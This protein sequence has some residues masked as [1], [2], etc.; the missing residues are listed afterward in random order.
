[1]RQT[2]KLAEHVWYKV[3]TA[4][5]NREPVF[6][7]GF[8]VGL[9][10]R[11]LIEAKG[12]FPF[13]MRGLTIGNEWLMF[14]IKPADGYELPKIMQWMKQTFSVRFNIVTWRTGHV[15]GD[16]Y[17]SEILPGEPPP[18]AEAVDWEW[19]KAMARK[20]IAGFIPYKLSWGCPRWTGIGEK[21]GDSPRCAFSVS[22]R[23]RKKRKPVPP[24]GKPAL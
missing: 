22:S 11:V 13:E 16:R 6:K 19:V 17:K 20:E 21:A 7:L 5:N 2:R 12:K 18:G 15:W 1:M 8:V 14:Y 4:I 24:S 23:R 10:C 3:S 9:F